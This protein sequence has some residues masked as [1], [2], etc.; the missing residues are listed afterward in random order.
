MVFKVSWYDDQHKIILACFDFE[1]TTDDV[2]QQFDRIT[3]LLDSVKHPVYV[4]HELGDVRRFA[5]VSIN[6]ITRVVRHPAVTHPS[7]AFSYFINGNR[8]AEI[9]IELGSRLFPAIVTN[10]AFVT[11]LEEA[12]QDIAQREAVQARDMPL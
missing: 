2:I 10:L 12:L 1:V 4:C 5:Q 6:A 11:T 8:R 3:E 7:R 9:V